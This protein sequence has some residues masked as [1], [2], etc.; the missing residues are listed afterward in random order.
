MNSNRYRGQCSRRRG[1]RALSGRTAALALL[2][3]A[4]VIAAG[5]ASV[6]AAE[7]ATETN[8]GL[9][10]DELLLDYSGIPE[11][12]RYAARDGQELSVRHYPSDSNVVLVLIHGSGYHS[13]YL[14][15]LAR[16]V[17]AANAAQVYTPDLR[18]HGVAPER[19]GD[20]D[21][22]DQLEDD[23]ADLVAHIRKETPGARIVVGG[24]SSGGG[25]ALRFAG[26]QYGS[27]ASA[28]LLLAPFLRHDAP[29]TRPDA[30]GWAKPRVGRIVGLSILNQMGINAWDDAVVIEFEMPED[31]RDGTETLAYTHRLNTGFAP[32]AFETDLAAIGAPLLVLVGADDEA[33]IAEQFTPTIASHAPDGVVEIVE[34]AS[35]M[36]IV[37]GEASALVIIPWLAAL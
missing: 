32:R 20:T 26:S 14:F 29:T 33:F 19:R 24:H 2:L 18:G 4:A 37:V 15:P 21:Y 30:G 25:L 35:H 36:G 16:R 6:K 3:A 27:E 1:L 12:T 34:G 8:G 13:R 28:V 22:I 10:F 31:Y 9:R 7:E 23:L 5:E 11:L 17:S